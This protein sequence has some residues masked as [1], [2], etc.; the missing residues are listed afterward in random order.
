MNNELKDSRV[1]GF[2]G[3][4]GRGIRDQGAGI[5]EQEQGER[6]KVKRK[7]PE[8]TNQEPEIDFISHT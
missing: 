8:T 7:K 4:R 6:D 5:G 3:S 1:R 2:E